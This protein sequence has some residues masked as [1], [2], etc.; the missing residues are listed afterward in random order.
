MARTSGSEGEENEKRG[1]ALSRQNEFIKSRSPAS[2]N[3]ER[4]APHRFAALFRVLQGGIGPLKL[5]LRPSTECARCALC[6]HAR[7]WCTRAS[8][9]RYGI[10]WR[11]HSVHEKCTL[12]ANNREILLHKPPPTGERVPGV[13][14]QINLFLIAR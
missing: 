7:L 3:L 11:R 2:S 8:V 6:V 12:R 5:A 1:R 10:K 14:A 4:N 13:P 9:V